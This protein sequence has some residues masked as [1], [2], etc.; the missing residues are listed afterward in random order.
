MKG[1]NICKGGNMLSTLDLDTVNSFLKTCKNEIDNYD[2]LRRNQLI[3]ENAKGHITW[4]F[5][6]IS[7]VVLKI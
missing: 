1:A 7:V 3:S 6:Y 2:E 4:R 5:D